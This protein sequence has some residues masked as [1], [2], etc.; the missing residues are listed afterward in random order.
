[1]LV[2]TSGLTEQDYAEINIAAHAAF[3]NTL[4]GCPN[5]A[6]RV[7]Y[8][9]DITSPAAPDNMR[10]WFSTLAAKSS[11]P[12]DAVSD[13]AERGFVVLPGPVPPRK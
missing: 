11:L 3:G 6:V 13:L 9:C 4:S 7:E 5:V 1:M 8:R 12:G 2:G 10:D